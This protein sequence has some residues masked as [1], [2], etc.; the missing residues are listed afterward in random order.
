MERKISS[1][2]IIMR[3]S[4]RNVDE[5]TTDGEESI[6]H[7]DFFWWYALSPEVAVAKANVSGIKYK[8]GQ[9]I[10]SLIETVQAKIRSIR[11][12]MNL[13]AKRNGDHDDREYLS[14]NRL[15]LRGVRDRTSKAESEALEKCIYKDKCEER[16]RWLDYQ[17]RKKKKTPEE[18]ELEEFLV[19]SFQFFTSRTK[20]LLSR[21]QKC[22]FGKSCEL[23]NGWYATCVITEN[24][25]SLAGGDVLKAIEYL[26]GHDDGQ[27]Q[28]IPSRGFRRINDDD[29]PDDDTPED[30]VPEDGISDEEPIRKKMRLRIRNPGKNELSRLIELEHSLE[31]IKDFNRGLMK[32][33][34][35]AR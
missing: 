9:D 33:R 31:F 22:P 35:C 1:L 4:R 11:Q 13:L 3:R 14:E 34:K 7:A 23:C 32:S 8:F 2:I 16:Q 24:E 18:I 5:K 15:Y 20:K 21:R 27:K 6:Q 26:R 17:S 19:R 10:E 28:I 12:R 29:I 30:D 25:I